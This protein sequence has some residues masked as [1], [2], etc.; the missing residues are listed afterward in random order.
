[1]ARH[2]GQFDPNNPEPYELS[3][4]RIENFVRCPACFYMQQ[5]EKISFPSIPGFLLN[6]A[7]DVL[8]KTYFD[9][10]RSRQECPDYL[11]NQGYY[12][13]IPFQHTDFELWTQSLHFGASGRM[14]TNVEEHNLKVGGGLD[15][16]W[17]NTDSGKLHIVD[18]KSTSKKTD[19]PELLDGFFAQA[20]KRQMDFYVWVM[21]RMGFDVCDTGYFLYVNGDRDT[22]VDF[23]DGE[24][25]KMMFKVSL[26]PYDVNTDWIEG[27][28]AE[29]KRTLHLPTRPN[30]AKACEYGAFL[31]AAY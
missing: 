21:R 6:E 28:L 8:L 31:D 2:R 3:R 18:Y 19:G 9:K 12:H 11:R 4:S 16:V 23:L 7:T 24:H 20:Y 25:G 10:F 5:V 15:D 27:T 29:I 13:L 1:M 17:Y 30:H 22:D 26:L 14:H